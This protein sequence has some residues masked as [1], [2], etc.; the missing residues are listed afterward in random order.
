LVAD[1]VN[2]NMADRLRAH[3]IC[4]IDTAGN[5]FIKTPFHHVLSKGNR[6]PKALDR[7]GTP[8]KQRGF[9]ATGLKVTYALLCRPEL[10]NEPYREIAAIAAVALGT[11]GKVIEDLLQA[12]LLIERDGERR[13]VRQEDL[14]ATWV[15]RYPAAL[16]HKLHLGYFQAARADW[17]ADFPIQEFGGLWGGE[18]AGAHYTQYLQPAVAT[19]YLPKGELRNLI[20]Q[21]RLRKIEL[22]TYEPGMVEVLTPFWTLEPTEA[23][24][25]H[26][27]LA[28]ADLIATDDP[29]NLEAARKLYD[30]RI[31][32]YLG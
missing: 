9:T 25:V 20:A 26:P 5:A 28:Y 10:V 18:I 27:I 19:I 13:L 24:F 15:D 3:G 23:P 17:W 2:P 31:A 14:L 1:Y 12:G 29:R 21:A 16:R 6:K 4:F 22:P 8:R 30:D 32:R 7:P 11:V